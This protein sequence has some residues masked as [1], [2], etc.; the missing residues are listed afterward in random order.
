MQESHFTEN[1]R[2]IIIESSV[3]L[4]RVIAD[5]KELKD[6][7]AS[8]VSALENQKVDKDTYDKFCKETTLLTEDHEKRLRRN[9]RYLYLAI[10]GFTVLQ[11]FI[12]IYFKK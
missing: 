4:E 10:G 11:I 9:E 2:R 7:F 12:D 6:N 8:R 1:D 3:K 5:V